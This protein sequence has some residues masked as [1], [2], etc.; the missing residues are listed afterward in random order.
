[1][2]DKKDTNRNSIIDYY[3]SCEID[4]KLFWDLDRS[5][6]M[7]AGYWDETTANLTAALARENQILAEWAG[8]TPQDVILD[9]GCGIGGS[10]IYLAKH[11]GCHV[12]GI[13][14]CE[15][16][17]ATAHEKALQHGV[18]GLTQFAVADYCR[19][20]FADASFDVVWG[21]ESICHAADKASFIREAFRLLRPGGRLIVA[22]GF[23]SQNDYTPKENYAMQKWLKGWGVESLETAAAFENHLLRQ[24]FQDISYRDITPQVTPSS[25]KLYWISFPGFVFS[26]LGEW[27]GQRTPMQTD[28]IKGAYYQYTTLKER[29]WR[30]GVFVAKKAK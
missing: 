23:A 4:Y 12:T 8:I 2:H 14:L 16:Q 20:P 27:L 10:A 17:A 25:R 29:L 18:A 3:N 24:G 11:F 15:K 1:M 9:A 7:H 6:A 28:N 26:K 21:L 5:L 22:D 30:Y 19:T 13:T